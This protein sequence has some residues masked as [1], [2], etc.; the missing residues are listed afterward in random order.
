M[1]LILEA[2]EL[3]NRATLYS[4]NFI[5]LNGSKSLIQQMFWEQGDDSSVSL[6]SWETELEISNQQNFLD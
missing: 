6:N 1:G 5:V 4:L 2:L 3:D